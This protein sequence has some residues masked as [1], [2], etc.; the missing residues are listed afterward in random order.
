[1]AHA[2]AYVAAR[3]NDGGSLLAVLKAL[4]SELDIVSFDVSSKLQ[5][6]TATFQNGKQASIR[7]IVPHRTA[8]GRGPLC[9]RIQIPAEYRDFE[10]LYFGAVD[11]TGRVFIH[12]VKSKEMRSPIRLTVA[13]E[14]GPSN[15]SI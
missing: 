6:M 2:I 8:H 13:C 5:R 1:M 10:T 3:S 14:F 9:L 12:K 15:S 7:T 4:E 11:A